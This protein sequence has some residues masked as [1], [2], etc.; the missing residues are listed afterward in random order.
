MIFFSP[1]KVNLFLRILRRRSDGY[2]DLA[3]LFQAVDLY[4]TLHVEFSEE[5][6]LTCNDLQVPLGPSN[7]IWKAIYLYRQQTGYAFKLHIQLDKKI[8]MEA[9]L[10]GGSSNAAT[11]L[12]AINAL[13]DHSISESELCKWAAEIGSDV[14]FFFSSGTAYCTGRGEQVNSLLP[15]KPS[16]F[17]I[18]KPLFGLSTPLVYNSLRA[19]LLPSRDPEAYLQTFIKGHHAYFNDLEPSAFELLPKLKE[20]RELLRSHGFEDVMMT[21]SGTAM[22]CFGEKIPSLSKEIFPFQQR[23]HFANRSPPHWYGN[24]QKTCFN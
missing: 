7:L 21:G 14:P 24:G 16:S 18:F 13:H 9:G 2:H 6:C 12:W 15:L 4:D 3:S 23:V 10:G 8:P 20:I 5:D 17:W 1:A 22:I 11:A 19:D